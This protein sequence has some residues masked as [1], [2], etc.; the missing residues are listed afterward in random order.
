VALEGIE[1]PP[2]DLPEADLAAESPQP[3]FGTYMPFDVA[4]ERL[5]KHKAFDNLL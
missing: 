5:I 1:P 2:I 4:S 3:L